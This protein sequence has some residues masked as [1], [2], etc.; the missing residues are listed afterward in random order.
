MTD[1][2]VDAFLFQS[3]LTYGIDIPFRKIHNELLRRAVLE[4]VKQL[5]INDFGFPV[6][7][8]KLTGGYILRNLNTGCE[9]F[10]TE[11]L[12]NNFS[13]YGI[14]VFEG[15][16]RKLNYSTFVQTSFDA[17][18]NDD[19]GFKSV[20]PADKDFVFDRLISVIVTLKIPVIEHHHIVKKR[21]LNGSAIIQFS[22][23]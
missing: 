12:L 3:T 17:I 13:A 20:K 9:Q 2:T 22:L 11:S 4:R 21:K 6:I 8:Y 14:P 18:E 5:L 19:V 1:I 23:P 16:Y 7:Y 10:T 15:G